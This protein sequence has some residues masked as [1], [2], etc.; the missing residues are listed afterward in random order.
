[1]NKSYTQPCELDTLRKCLKIEF[2]LIQ[3]IPKKRFLRI[4]TD[5]KPVINSLRISHILTQYRKK[6]Y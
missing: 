2:D 1:M 6:L 4:S 3:K 5:S